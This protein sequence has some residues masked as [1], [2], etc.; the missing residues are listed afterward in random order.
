MNEGITRTYESWYEG[1]YRK[2]DLQEKSVLG[3]AIRWIG[4]VRT[5]LEV[6]CGTAHF[7]RFFEESGIE[8]IGVDISPYML[9][10]ARRLWGGDKIIR[11]TSLHIP[12]EE[13]SVD[14]AGFVTCFEY[15]PR[16]LDVI[17]EAS[18]VARRG[19][20]F[21]LMNSWSVPTVRRRIQVALGKNDYYNTAHFYSILEVR[22]LLREALEG[23][24]VA[25]FQ[26]STVFPR[27]T[28]LRES[29]LPLGAFLCVGVRFDG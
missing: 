8:A 19:I 27:L 12:L 15:M 28:L 1:K 25:T 16:P 23:G 9:K 3:E 24:K 6:G 14:A 22:R 20:F 4:G 7:S 17:R 21:G 26:R 10:E 2:A 29:R 11:A 13:K 18:R 5:I